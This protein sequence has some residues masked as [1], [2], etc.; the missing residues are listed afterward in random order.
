M[1][2]S[3]PSTAPTIPARSA[4]SSPLAASACTT[5]TSS[6]STSACTWAPASSCCNNLTGPDLKL[7]RGCAAEIHVHVHAIGKLAG[8]I[9]VDQHLHDVIVERPPLP[10]R[11]AFRFDE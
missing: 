9:Q 6:I 7:P 3:M 11:N 2:I 1:W 4:I 8:V 5:A 10:P